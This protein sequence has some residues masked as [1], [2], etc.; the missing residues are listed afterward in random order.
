METRVVPVVVMV[1]SMEVVTG[2]MMVVV[3]D[4]KELLGSMEVVVTI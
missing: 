2:F 3:E 4:I 1:E